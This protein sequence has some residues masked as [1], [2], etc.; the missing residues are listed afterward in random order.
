MS[1]ANDAR[2]DGYGRIYQ[3]S[4]DQHIV[5]HHH[6]APEWAGPDSVRHP[7]VGRTPVVLRDRVGEMDRLRAAVEPGV[8][9]RAYVLHGMGGCGKTAVAHA[10]FRHATDHAGRVGLWVNASDPASLRA[11]MLAVA[12][13]R[14]ATDAELTGARSGLRPAADLVWHYLDASDRPWLLVL[15]NADTPAILRDGGWLRTSPAGIVVVT[16]RQAAARWWP[17][18]ELL[19]FGVLPREDAA[20]VLQDLAPHAGSAE[21]AA[22]VAD[23]LGHLPLAL[24]LAGG[25]LAH[26][27]IDP[28]SLADYRHGLEGGA[29][30]HPIELL[31]R[32]AEADAES[33]H[34]LSRTWQLSLEAL[35]AQGL[36][37]ATALLRLLACW[38][39]DPLPLTLLSG[40]DLGAELHPSRVES[41]LRGLLDHSLVELVPGRVRC[42][43]VHGILLDSVARATPAD[44][45]ELLVTTAAHLLGAVLPEV[46]ERGDQDPAVI[47]IAPHAIALLRRAVVDQS[48]GL[49][50]VESA[51]D[52]VLRLVIAVHRSGDY[53]SALTLANEA[54]ELATRRLPADNVFAL[55]LR[56]RVGRALFRLGRFEESETV[57]EGV[58]D[59]CERTLG[60]DAPDTLE[61]S[62]RLGGP[63]FNLGRLQEAILLTRRA[64]Q[65]RKEALG[66]SHPLT[67][68]ARKCLLEFAAHPDAGALPDRD[69][70]L[71]TGPAVI[72]DCRSAAGEDHP[73]TLGAVLNY[74][75]ALAAAER[76]AE[77][78]PHARTAV[79]GYARLYDPDYPLLLNARRT[80]SVALD[81]LGRHTE[82][83]E[84]G[85]ILVEGRTRVL[86]PTHPWTV[87]AEELLR[88]YRAGAAR[89]A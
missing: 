88:H 74:A 62:L 44:Q 52:R 28:W 39:G 46:P 83:I 21:E 36:P 32:G 6:H 22:E 24:T 73:M 84:Q 31:D 79:S 65:G 29:D 60:P 51:V 89:S 30:L 55:R 34:L 76:P 56:M 57:Y 18:A 72:A 63:F 35:T 64:V 13:D 47:L 82:A 48:V 42:L 4:G 15:D 86:G 9:N 71:A 7:A 2:A 53:A 80:L 16:T 27:I 75:Y 12:A 3:A 1:G 25:F 5:E 78:L 38:A 41:A 50:V 17:G 23:R 66:A 10:L 8:G 37:E 85:E 33:R 87:H 77:A 81:A 11:G 68:I 69:E 67:L 26:Q 43:R 14:G 19:Q 45:R 20:L 58:L 70:I 40:A 54:L 49:A 61:V 59:D